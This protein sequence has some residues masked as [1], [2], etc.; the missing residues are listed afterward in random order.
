MTDLAITLGRT[1]R[2]YLWLVWLALLIVG[3]FLWLHPEIVAWAVKYPRAMVVPFAAWIGAVVKWCVANLQPFTRAIAALLDAPLRFVQAAL[4]TGFIHN[5]QE[6]IFPRLSWLGVIGA[7]TL[8]GHAYGG[9]R[10]AVL[11]FICFAY[12]AVFDQWDSTMLTLASVIICAPMGVVV[13]MLL[14][15]L[16]Y[17]VPLVDTWFIR[18]TLDMAQTMPAFAYLVPILLLFGSG[19][20]PALIATI[21]F[22][23]PPMVRA[24]KLALEQVPE[25]IQSF[26]DMTGCTR[27]QKL[28]RV[29]VPTAQ[30]LLMVGVNQV[31]MM[32][33]NMVIIA[34]M[35]GSGGLG[36]DVLMAL[37]ALDIDKGLVAGSAIIVV[38]VSLDRISTAAAKKTFIPP[39]PGAGL[40][41]RHPYLI[42][43]VAW[44]AATTLL[45]LSVPALIHIP[46]E[47][48]I[49]SGTTF[50]DLV[51][52]INVNYFDTIDA[53][54]TWL[55]L[56]FLN[57]I[58]AFLVE[59]PWIF[60]VSAIG[61]LGYQ[62]AGWRLALLV[63]L[64]MLF[65]AVTGQ[66][67]KTMVTVYL[68]SISA[69]IAAAIGMALGAWG[70]RS[71]AANRV[72]TVVVDT[73]QTLPGFVY[74]IPAVMLLR[75]GDV[76]AMFAIVLFAVAPAIRYTTHGIRQVAPHLL[77]ASAAPVG[78][79]SGGSSCRSP[80]RRSCW[81]ST[82]PF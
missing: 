30:P 8:A 15:V 26:A 63:T 45:G 73:L 61:L 25:E 49:K 65:P 17:R 22:A 58:K 6:E 40:W 35:I 46:P 74:L 24:T 66:W 68:C 19:P 53:G 55:L 37:R 77:E 47:W 41:Q 23:A 18:P 42:V 2:S 29:M 10:V 16:A 56:N 59:L 34:S 57:P 27:R 50:M 54:R 51:A 60:V 75:I 3:A 76:A 48:T 71:E 14:G 20:V 1:P 11:S 79:C 69:M 72:L 62:L 78:R 21:I 38:A 70:A 39:P 28:W 7:F 52:W 33:L 82:R 44:L 12:V 36:F 9:I 31:I 64:L 81:A 67:E 5:G 4:A 13:G 43:S 80:C 32:T